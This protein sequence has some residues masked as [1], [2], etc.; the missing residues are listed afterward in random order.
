MLTLY[1]YRFIKP[2]HECDEIASEIFNDLKIDS[3][4]V[5]EGN[6]RLQCLGAALSHAV[7]LLESSCLD[8]PARIMTFVGGPCTRGPGNIVGVEL[9]NVIRTWTEIIDN[10]EKQLM[11]D[12][13]I[14]KDIKVK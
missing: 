10:E 4:P 5:T 3:W 8:I 9:T 6:R 7:G 1:I 2:V 13:K 14:G 11:K 12:K